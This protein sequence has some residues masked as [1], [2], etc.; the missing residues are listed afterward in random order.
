[1]D[2]FTAALKHVFEV[3]GGYSDHPDDKG[4]ETR[5]GITAKTYHSFIEKVSGIEKPSVRNITKI[6]AGLIYRNM[7]WDEIK[8][9]ELPIG[10]SLMVF[11]SAVHA[12]PTQAIKWL[13]RALGEK[14]D[15]IFGPIT[16]AAATYARDGTYVIERIAVY[17][18][19]LARANE[20]FV[21]GWFNRIVRTL[22][23]SIE[24]IYT[25]E[26]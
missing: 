26:F 3:E 10:L 17:R 8:G 4:G 14:V 9:D 7:Y 11:D 12:G 6:E 20:T 16:L 1:M 22:A 13:Q 2:N 18:L 24:T 5:F 21:K 23:A 25:E 19:M 15:G